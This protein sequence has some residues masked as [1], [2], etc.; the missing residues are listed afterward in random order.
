MGY[1]LRCLFQFLR[2][3]KMTVALMALLSQ[4]CFAIVN[5]KVFNHNRLYQQRKRHPQFGLSRSA[6]S[7]QQIYSNPQFF[8]FL[9]WIARAIFLLGHFPLCNIKSDDRIN[10]FITGLKL[11]NNIFF[12]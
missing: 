9:E 6:E 7:P 2:V 12:F 5:E 11:F 10:D 3:L 4:T 8:D 1:W